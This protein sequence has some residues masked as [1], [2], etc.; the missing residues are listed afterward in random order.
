MV[1]VDCTHERGSKYTSH[2]T[3]HTSHVTR[4]TSHVTRHTATNGSPGAMIVF[5]MTAAAPAKNVTQKR[6]RSLRE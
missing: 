4:H 3:R 1:P 2:V 5:E 6:V